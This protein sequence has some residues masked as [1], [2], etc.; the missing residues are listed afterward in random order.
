[1]HNTDR[2]KKWSYFIIILDLVY[3]ELHNKLNITLILL[4]SKRLSNVENSSLRML[5]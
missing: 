3:I 4:Q 1:M 5:H 2:D